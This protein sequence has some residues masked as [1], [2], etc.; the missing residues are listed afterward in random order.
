MRR[1]KV[2]KKRTCAKSMYSIFAISQPEEELHK[3]RNQKAGSTKQVN[4]FNA[5]LAVLYYWM[6]N[7]FTGDHIATH[8]FIMM[9]LSLPFISALELLF[10]HCFGFLISL[11]FSS[12]L[13]AN[14]YLPCTHKKWLV[15]SVF[16]H[17]SKWKLWVSHE[18]S[19]EWTSK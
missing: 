9:N 8:L 1:N 3:L 11:S 5:F 17:G 13:F 19:N 6:I 18:W 7:T 15:R 2:E 4:Q 16:R 10:L 12:N 14:Y